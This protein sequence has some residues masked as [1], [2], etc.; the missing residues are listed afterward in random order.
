LKQVITE[1]E[2]ALSTTLQRPVAN[3]TLKIDPVTALIGA[4]V[5]GID[6]RQSL[7][8]ET[9]ARLR[10]ALLKYKVLFFRDQDISDA[11]QIRFTRYFGAVT[12]AHPVTN[13][14]P[15]LPEIKDNRLHGGEPEYR[16]FRL[17]VDYPLRPVSRSR[18]GRGWHIDITFVANP[19]AISVLR[20]VEIPAYGGDTAWVDLEA[21]Y[22]S[23]S[24]PLRS[25]VDGLQAIHVRDD[26]AS[27]VQRPPRDDGRS[28][29]PF[30]SLHPLVRV[31]PETKR[32]SLFLSPGF[33]KAIDGLTPSESAALL[34][35]L[36]EELAGHLDFQVRFRWT[37]GAIAI[38]D[39]RSAAH[40][41][42][43]DGPHVKEQRIVHRTT[44]GGDQPE[45]PGGF[46]SRPLVGELFNVIS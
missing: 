35:H 15:G 31:H 4:D 41:G 38:W 26:A 9:V 36:N 29:G 24:A 11:Q 8:P 2:T 7:E 28:T 1:K 45:G 42:P 10:E 21:L 6:L 43:V 3:R 5:S 44:V 22:N 14:V 40:F 25:F 16:S 37:Q 19:A 33:I 30:A 39:N 20:G 17:S 13:G 46:V 27:G 12:P 34:D 32:R 18:S 23:L